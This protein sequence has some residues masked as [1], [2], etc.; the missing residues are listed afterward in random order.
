MRFISFWNPQG[1]VREI[2]LCSDCGCH[3]ANLLGFQYD[4]GKILSLARGDVIKS[5]EV[6]GPNGGG[7]EDI[8][9]NGVGGA[10][11]LRWY[12]QRPKKLPASRAYWL[13]KMDRD[14]RR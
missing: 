8:A 1:D 12:S 4:T 5:V 14:F 6:H 9:M 10:H 11:N 2:S 7:L 13:D 3:A